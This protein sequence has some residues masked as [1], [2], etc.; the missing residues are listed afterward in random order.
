MTYQ[1][2]NIEIQPLPPNVTDLTGQRYGRLT[3]ISFVRRVSINPAKWAYRYDWLCECIC[4]NRKVIDSS[5]FKSGDTTS[6]GCYQRERVPRG[7]RANGEYVGGRRSPEMTAFVSARNRCENPNESKYYNYGG[8]GIEFRF[9]SF[10]EFLAE[11]GR[12]P[13]PDHSLDRIN[14]DRHYEIGNVR[15][16]TTLQQ[17]R[18]KR[19][20]KIIQVGEASHCVSEWL[21]ISGIS[22]SCVLYRRRQGWCDGCAVSL[23]PIQRGTRAARQEGICPHII[24]T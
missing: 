16:A 12:R 8:R 1:D 20:N 23:P 19:T 4:G 5:H 7:S 21:E 17:A 14:N 2:F 18:N 11:V 13:S 15:W 10:E 22:S 6:C 3:V 24:D 9:D